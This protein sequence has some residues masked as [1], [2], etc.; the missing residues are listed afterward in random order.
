[1]GTRRFPLVDQVSRKKPRYEENHNS[2][3]NIVPLVGTDVVPLVD[4]VIVP[5]VGTDIVP[6]VGTDIVPSTASTNDLEAQIID[7]KRSLESSE[8]AVKEVKKELSIRDGK[9]IDQKRLLEHC[10][11]E[12]KEDKEKI[13]VVLT[14]IKEQSL[15][16]DITVAHLKESMVLS[17]TLKEDV[18]FLKKECSKKESRL[19]EFEDKYSKLKNKFRKCLEKMKFDEENHEITVSSMSGECAQ[20]TLKVKHLEEIHG[21]SSIDTNK[22]SNNHPEENLLVE[23]IDGPSLSKS[24]LEENSDQDVVTSEMKNIPAPGSKTYKDLCDNDKLLVEAYYVYVTAHGHKSDNALLESLQE[25]IG[26][27][28]SMIIRHLCQLRYRMMQ[29]LISVGWGRSSFWERM[30]EA[31]EKQRGA[32]EVVVMKEL[33]LVSNHTSRSMK[34]LADDQLKRIFYNFREGNLSV[35]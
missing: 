35:D 32:S 3:Y 2:S 18:S 25:K 13:K 27:P 14:E 9:I 21:G 28:R 22:S 1:M 24:P 20:L 29:K 10:E 11:K 8:T 16:Q 31:G 15:E 23:N 12:G 4:T 5:L 7:L 19:I 17:D 26:L 30:T 34:K 6:L 33:K